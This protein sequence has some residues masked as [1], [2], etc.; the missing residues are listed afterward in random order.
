ML[1]T[2]TTNPAIDVNVTTDRVAPGT[3][4]RTRDMVFTP[5]GKG[6]NHVKAFRDPKRYYGLFRRLYRRLHYRVLRT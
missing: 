6:L 2:L 4:N 1:Y 5:N 3:V